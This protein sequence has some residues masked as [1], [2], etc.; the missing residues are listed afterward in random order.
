M[1][2]ISS[3]KRDQKAKQNSIYT[4]LHV[5]VG[6]KTD[7]KSEKM[8]TNRLL[9]VFQKKAAGSKWWWQKIGQDTIHKKA[10]TKNV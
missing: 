5:Q 4:K 9:S 1:L 6:H 7:R 3:I 8:G 2:G 10:T